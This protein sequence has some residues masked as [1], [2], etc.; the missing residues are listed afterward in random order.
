V[1]L[2]G[3]WRQAFGDEFD[4]TRLDATKWSDH[5]AWQPKGFGSDSAWYTVPH[6]ER[7]LGVRDGVLTMR[8]RRTPGLSGGATFTSAHINTW[9][10]FHIPTGSTSFVEARLKA[11]SAAGTLPAFWL[12]GNGTN[13]DGKGW[14]ISGEVDVL[15]FANNTGERGAPYFSVWYPKDVYSKAPGSFLNGT[16]DTHPTSWAKRPELLDSW[17]TWGL[18]RSPQTMELFI[19]GRR[20]ATFRPGQAYQNGMRLPP[21]LFTHAQHLR[22]SLGVGGAWAGAGYTER[23]YQP[24]DLAVDH[25]RAWLL[26]DPG[27]G[28]APRT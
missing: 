10:K 6:T 19:D 3:V 13:G 18:L 28:P 5:D 7:E 21:V 20:I 2:P 22:L 23:Q 12:L 26:E 11:P 17:H 27:R 1:G 15:E 16:H 25:V 24:G 14:P 8:A 9:H 4:G